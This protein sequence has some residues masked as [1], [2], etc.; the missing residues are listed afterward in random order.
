[1]AKYRIVAW[2][3]VPA[4]V[5]ATDS[6]ETVTRP[7][8]ERFQ[9]LIDSA[10]MQLGIHESDAYIEQWTRGEAQERAGSAQ[11]VADAIVADL[12]NR[13]PEFIGQAFRLR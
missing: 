2:R 8:S 9:M 4:S 11:E 10:A 12:E 3:G 6:T 7:L 5:E 13:F 1:M